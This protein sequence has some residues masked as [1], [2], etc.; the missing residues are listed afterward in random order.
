VDDAL[1]LA[2]QAAGD[3]KRSHNRLFEDMFRLSIAEARDFLG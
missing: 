1:R 2:E 3:A